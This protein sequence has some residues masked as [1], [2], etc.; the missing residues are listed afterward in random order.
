MKKMKRYIYVLF[1]LG[2]SF[3]CNVLNQD[4][5]SITAAQTYYTTDAQ[6]SAAANTIYYNICNLCDRTCR[7]NEICL[8]A[9]DVTTSPAL[10]DM[11]EAETYHIS[12]SNDM[13][14]Y[15]W[16]NTYK[17][18]ISCNNIIVNSDKVPDSDVKNAAL[19]QAYFAR[20]WEYFWLVRMHNRIPLITDIN[21]HPN[22]TLSEPQ[23][24]YDQ[25]VND[26]QKAET[27]L[28]DSYPD[29]RMHVAYTKGTAKSVLSLVYLTMAGYPVKNTSMYALAASKAKEVMDHAGTWGYALL[30][31]YADLWKN[32]QWNPEIVLGYF[33]NNNGGVANQ[34][35]PY[36]GQP[37]EWTGWD[38]YFAELNF[39]KK[40]PEGARKDATFETA[41]PVQNADGSTSVVDYTQLKLKH[42]YYK[43][44]WDHNGMNWTQPWQYNDWTSSR[45]TIAMRYAEVLLTYAEAQSMAASPDASAYD[46]VNKVRHRA[47]LPDLTPGLSQAAFRDSVI[48]E[49]SWEFAGIE[50]NGSNWFDLVRTETVE[51]AAADRDPSEIP[52]LVAPTHSNYFAPIPDND[53]L[54]NPNLGK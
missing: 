25:I 16:E 8:G 14:L 41:Y 50:A 33:Y 52:I 44:M 27:L 29:Y 2:T 37:S 49:R 26:L 32:V 21:T 28:P 39:Y 42:P 17:V 13:L 19:G 5:E 54:L 11:V 40:F 10:L 7:F 6:L 34:G 51:A 47:G 45:T 30:D 46:A 22:I 48:A 12:S 43:K 4:F 53:V 15:W 1:L 18:I 23:A 9:N 20:G 24:V 3:S 38:Y 35:A 31:N 36:P